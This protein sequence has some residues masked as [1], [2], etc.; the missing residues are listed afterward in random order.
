MHFIL[1]SL[2][3]S[4]PPSLYFFF[5]SIISFFLALLPLLLPLLLYLSIYSPAD[6]VPFVLS[7]MTFLRGIA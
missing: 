2:D 6:A 7:P 1:S 4:Q 5:F 3:L